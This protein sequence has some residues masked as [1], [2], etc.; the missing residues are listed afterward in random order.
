MDLIDIGSD[1]RR[2][3]DTTSEYLELLE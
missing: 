2:G 1:A 3:G